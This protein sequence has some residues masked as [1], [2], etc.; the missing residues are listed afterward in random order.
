MRPVW[1][2]AA[3]LLGAGVARAQDTSMVQGGIYQRPYIVRV[4]RTAVGGYL[5]AH[6][7]RRQSDGIAEGP[8]FEVRRFNLFLYSAAGRRLR[9]T[10][11]LEFEHGTE[12]I[13]LETALV[14]FV[15]NPSLVLRAG[16]LLPPIGAFNVNHDG[17]RYEFVDR[18]FVATGIVPSTLSETGLGVHGRLA[19]HGFS[20]SYDAYL[21]N[22][23]GEGVVLNSTGRTDFPSGKGESLFAEDP[24][25]SPAFSARIAAQA[26][27]LGEV[28]LSHYR[29]VYNVWRRE[30][31]T[32]D[33]KRWLSLSALDLATAIGP[34]ELRGEAAL[35]DVD[36]PG[37]LAEVHGDRQWGFYLD[38]VVPVW[39][40]RIRALADPVVNVALR[41]ERVDWNVGRFSATGRPRGDDLTAATFGLGF[42]PVAGTVFRFNYRRE[43]FR[44]LQG[45]PTVHTGVLHLGVATYY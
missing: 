24:N 2:G 28:G 9:V 19:P 31:E 32:V 7:T 44:D 15:V 1:V 41:M 8:S 34:V 25:G 42:R 40:P 33:Q 17:P 35:A 20:L 23:L 27:G 16:V 22:G 43:W 45:N 13:A 10:T 37:D 12:E 6:G 14:D 11:E 29:G 18:P 5:E 26:R 3:A 30:G 4:D 36:V 39:R 38:A 21:T